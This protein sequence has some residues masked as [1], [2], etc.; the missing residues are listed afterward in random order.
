MNSLIISGRICQDPEVRYTQTGKPVAN[1]SI[2][3]PIYPKPPEGQPDAYFFRCVAWAGA[4]EFA[5]KYLAKGDKVLIR[6]EI[7]TESYTSKQTGQTVTRVVITAVQQEIIGEWRQKDGPA[8]QKPERPTS[9]PE[10]DDS[11]FEG[12][13]FEV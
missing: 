12:L 3:V 1:Y 9:E 11:I 2:A 7:K 6:G 4:A 13:P 10:P 8:Q 5:Q